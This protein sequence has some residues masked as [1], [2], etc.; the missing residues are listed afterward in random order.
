MLNARPITG[1]VLTLAHALL[2]LPAGL[3]VVASLR[4]PIVAKLGVP[5]GCA[6]ILIGVLRPGTGAT[7][8]LSSWEPW[9][10]PRRGLVSLEPGGA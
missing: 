3:A 7:D 4:G 6:L 10:S 5:L 1:R 2:L 8:I 9:S